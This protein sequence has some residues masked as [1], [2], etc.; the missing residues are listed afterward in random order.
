MG[1]TTRHQ[2][3]SEFVEDAPH[4]HR[5]ESLPG[6]LEESEEDEGRMTDLVR[7]FNVSSGDV[8]GGLRLWLVT[9]NLVARPDICVQLQTL[10][11]HAATECE[12]ARRQN[13]PIVVEY[14]RT[15]YGPTL[16][17]AYFVKAVA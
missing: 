11:N 14:H 13:R 7:V 6:P 5:K 15:Q 17:A 4:R 2:T 8:R 9:A 1:P 12:V 16:R 10:S 3:Q